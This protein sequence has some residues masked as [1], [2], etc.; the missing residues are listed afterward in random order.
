[1]SGFLIKSDLYVIRFHLDF[2]TAP[3]T[4]SAFEKELPFAKTFYHARVSGFEIWIDN[5][6]ELNY[7]YRK[8]PLYLL[9]PEK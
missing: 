2:S 7:S 4:S 8:M 3:L 1:M 6:P 5:A 9:I